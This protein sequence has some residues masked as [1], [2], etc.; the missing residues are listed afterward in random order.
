[1][2]YA[3]IFVFDVNQCSIYTKTET[4]IFKYLKKN[5]GTLCKDV[6]QEIVV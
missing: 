4:E 6:E 3:Y 2:Q 1:M 5:N